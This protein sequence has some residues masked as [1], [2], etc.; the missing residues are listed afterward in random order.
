LSTPSSPRNSLL[1]IKPPAFLITTAPSPEPSN[2]IELPVIDPF[3]QNQGW[4]AP[5]ATSITLEVPMRDYCLSPIHEV[6]TPLATPSHSPCHTPMMRRLST[7]NVPCIKIQLSSEDDDG[8]TSARSCSSGSCTSG[9]SKKETQT[10]RKVDIPMISISVEE[11]FERTEEANYNVPGRGEHTRDSRR[12]YFSFPGESEVIPDVLIH[13]PPDACVESHPEAELVR[14]PHGTVPSLSSPDCIGSPRLKNRPP[15]LVFANE[16]LSFN[17]TTKISNE[18]NEDTNM[19]VVVPL[20]SIEY[21]TPVSEIMPKFISYL[22]EYDYSAGDIT[23]KCI[24]PP[25]QTCGIQFKDSPLAPPLITINQSSE[26]ESDSDTPAHR[27]IHR[28]N[29][30]F[31][32]PFAGASDRVPS[33][34]NLS[35]SGYS[36]MASPCPSRCPS[37]SPLCPSEAEDYHSHCAHMHSHS[38]YRRSSLTPGTPKKPPMTPRR[39]SLNAPQIA[40]GLLCDNSDKDNIINAEKRKDDVEIETDSAVEIETDL[41][42]QANIS[43]VDAPP[44]TPM[45]QRPYLSIISEEM[46]S[47]N[48]LLQV[49]KKGMSKS[50]SLDINALGSTHDYSSQ[51]GQKSG[52]GLSDGK[53]DKKGYLRGLGPSLDSKLNS[54]DPSSISS[55]NGVTIMFPLSTSTSNLS[56]KNKTSTNLIEIPEEKERRLS[57]VSSRSESPLSELSAAGCFNFFGSPLTDSDGVYDCGSSEVPTNNN[58]TDTTN[59]ASRS[60]LL[61]LSRLNPIRRSGGRKKDRKTNKNSYKLSLNPS[62]MSTSQAPYESNNDH[63]NLPIWSISTASPEHPVQDQLTAQSPHLELPPNIAR[64]NMLP[65][66]IASKRASPKR[67]VRAQRNVDESSSSSESCISSSRP[68]LVL[69]CI[70]IDHR[71]E[72]EGTKEMMREIG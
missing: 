38:H 13:V 31:L 4:R 42:C 22:K 41:D 33:E 48:F 56:E 25:I 21:A 7:E 67:R 10:P 12:N 1:S 14:S 59:G 50:R 27:H 23:P 54:I 2:T 8:S 53:L 62:C 70:E 72:V 32:S 69:T 58:E 60:N 63:P 16:I 39:C 46:K 24:S 6:P 28:P 51:L 3:T 17:S 30:C 47:F 64:D 55:S 44:L 40:S 68:R 9:G 20:V 19:K 15:P 61:S 52:D 65:A 36:S 37:V 26:A 66:T 11:E 34:S 45:Y 49:P 35:T 71:A 5:P 43:E 57:P 29:L 18:E